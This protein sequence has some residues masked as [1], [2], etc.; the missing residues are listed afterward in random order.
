MPWPAHSVGPSHPQDT[1]QIRTLGPR[2]A[3]AG[4]FGWLNHL[5]GGSVYLPTKVVRS[6]G[7]KVKVASWELATRIHSDDGRCAVGPTALTQVPLAR[8]RHR[9]ALVFVWLRLRLFS[10][11]LSSQWR[12]ALELP[13]PSGDERRR[14]RH[15]EPRRAL[16]GLQ[17]AHALHRS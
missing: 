11:L 3:H 14:L 13:W 2:V 6:P 4:H 12:P 15:L 9:V 1:C 17:H 10:S 7:I 8:H 5:R 16:C